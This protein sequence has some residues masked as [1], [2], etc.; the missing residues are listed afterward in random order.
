MDVFTCTQL[1]KRY[2]KVEALQEVTLRLEQGKIYG[3][4]GNNGAGKTTLMKIMMGLVKPSGGSFTLFGETSP[5]G[6]RLARRRIG[7]L[8]ELPILID[9]LSGYQNVERIRILLG[10]KEKEETKRVLSI[11]GLEGAARRMAIN[12]S[13]GMKQRLGIAMALLGN[14]E[15]LVLDEP[16]NGLDPSGIRE[17][18]QLFTQLNREEKT[19]ILISSHHLS[20]LQQMATDYIFLHHGKVVEEID[21]L[22]LHRRCQSSILLSTADNRR[23][24]AL[25]KQA[26]PEVEIKKEEDKITLYQYDNKQKI[27]GILAVNQIPVLNLETVGQS[28]EEYFEQMVKEAAK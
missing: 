26:L 8:I 22:A 1:S 27:Y 4:I 16:I 20:Q 9:T 11:V 12:Y 7:T 21:S 5:K 17:M 2:Q 15:F 28:L 10:I 25:L 24:Y 13:L 19:T 23:A 18:E 3:L 14:P 6:I